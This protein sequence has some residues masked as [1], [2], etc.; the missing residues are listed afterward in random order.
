MSH[1]ID[2]KREINL[3]I[4]VGDPPD[5]EALRRASEQS[6][7]TIQYRVALPAGFQH[8]TK[9]HIVSIKVT[10]CVDVGMVIG[11]SALDLVATARLLRRR[12]DDNGEIRSAK[13]HTYNLVLR[14]M[15]TH[16]WIG[17]GTIGV[18]ADE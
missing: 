17:S 11:T 8:A 13:R 1:I 9:N 7:V 18:R 2:K 15:P 14:V 4:P 12:C 3:I 6:P 16:N 10:G 5:V